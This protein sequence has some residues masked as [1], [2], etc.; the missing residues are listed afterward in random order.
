MRWQPA[1]ATHTLAWLHAGKLIMMM[2]TLLE[3]FRH[4]NIRLSGPGLAGA[5]DCLLVNID[6]YHVIVALLTYGLLYLYL[7]TALSTHIV[8]LLTDQAT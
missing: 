3:I 5:W 2:W 4:L 7:P 1:T 8:R 6:T